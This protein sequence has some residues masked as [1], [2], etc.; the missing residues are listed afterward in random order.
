VVAL[1]E[2]DDGVPVQG[3][4]P[5]PQR[6]RRVRTGQAQQ[7]RDLRARRLTG[8]R[9]F[10]R[11]GVLVGVDEQQA[12]PAGAVAQRR[13][14]RE[15]NRTVRAVE[16]REAV[17]A[18]TMPDAGVDGV[19]HHQQCRFVDEA[20][21]AACAGRRGQDDVGGELRGRQRRLEA[22]RAERLRSPAWP[23]ERPIPS[24]RT[25]TRSIPATGSG[26][27]RLLRSNPVHDRQAVIVSLW[28]WNAAVLSRPASRTIPGLAATSSR[29][30]LGRIVDGCAEINS[31]AS[32]ASELYQM[33][34]LIR[35]HL[36]SDGTPARGRPVR[37]AR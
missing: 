1:T 14:R 29:E 16:Q 30:G 4:E 7:E 9:L 18:Q 28:T 25:P 21:R 15:Q 2:H 33:P 34:N 31:C 13:D 36:R 3:R 19:D 35:E 17:G 23:G 20:G 26:A 12:G 6:F 27:I 11:G 22:G 5:A 24:K 8:V 37:P 32:V 10:H